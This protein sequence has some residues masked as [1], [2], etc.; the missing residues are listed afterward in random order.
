MDRTYWST[1]ICSPVWQAV[2]CSGIIFQKTSAP[3]GSAA[4]REGPQVSAGGA[5]S[6]G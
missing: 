1:V 3:K 6:T 5:S 2:L 4:W